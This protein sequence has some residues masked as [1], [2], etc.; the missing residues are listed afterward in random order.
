MM[1]DLSDVELGFLVN[2]KTLREVLRGLSID[3]RRWWIA[4]DRMDALES[5][6]L[7]VGHGDPNCTDRLNTLYFNVPIL[8]DD[9]PLAGTDRLVLLLD[10]SVISP[11][12]PGLYIED[13]RVLTDGFTD[14]E[15]FYQPIRQALIAMLREA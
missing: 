8:P 7:T 15:C 9:R 6:S 5:H 13:G 3:G 10:Y 1:I 2:L 11:E 4:C 14:L 12:Q